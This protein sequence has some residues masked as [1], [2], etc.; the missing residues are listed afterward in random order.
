[1]IS[2]HI[3]VLSF[4][5]SD[6]S[7]LF[8]KNLACDRSF[9]LYKFPQVPNLVDDIVGHLNLKSGKIKTYKGSFT[10]YVITKGEGGFGMITLL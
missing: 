4:L 8:G 2:Y 10:Y 3:D 6:S 5:M 9:R 1:M 7:E